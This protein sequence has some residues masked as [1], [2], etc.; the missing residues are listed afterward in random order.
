MTQQVQ[1]PLSVFKK[2]SHDWPTGCFTYPSATSRS[3]PDGVAGLGLACA[4]EVSPIVIDST[5]PISRD[6]CAHIPS[7]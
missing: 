3:L 2:P 6:L 5:I 4:E 1:Q 7:L